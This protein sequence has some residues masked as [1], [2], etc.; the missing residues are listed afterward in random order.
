MLQ[1]LNKQY[2]YGMMNL[3]TINTEHVTS[4]LWLKIFFTCLIDFLEQF[5][6]VDSISYHSEPFF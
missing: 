2:A 5:C 4:T 3:L 1:I 6:E